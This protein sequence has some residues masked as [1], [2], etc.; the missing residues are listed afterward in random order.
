MNYK[1]KEDIAAEVSSDNGEFLPE[2]KRGWAVT[3]FDP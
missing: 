1:L 2:S 3:R